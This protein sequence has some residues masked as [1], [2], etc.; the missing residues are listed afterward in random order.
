MFVVSQTLVLG[1]HYGNPYAGG[2]QK[3]ELIIQIQGVPGA[4]CVPRCQGQGCP[5]DL[6]DGCTAD[7]KCVLRDQAGR[8][9]CALICDPSQ[10]DECGPGASCKTI[11]STGLCTYDPAGRLQPQ[12]LPFTVAHPVFATG[13]LLV[14]DE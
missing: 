6:P 11:Q 2:C 10:T 14:K 9:F 12:A 1:S 5:A 3:D 13:D 7:P 8:Q 4:I